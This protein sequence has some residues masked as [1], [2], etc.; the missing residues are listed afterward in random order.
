MYKTTFSLAV[1]QILYDHCQ[2][3]PSL[4]QLDAAEGMDVII[5]GNIMGNVN[6]YHTEG[7]G[8]GGCCCGCDCDDHEHDPTADN[9]D[10]EEPI[11][12]PDDDGDD[13]D[14]GD[15]M[16]DYCDYVEHAE[17]GPFKDFAST[18]DWDMHGFVTDWN[19]L[20]PQDVRIDSDFIVY[21]YQNI[22]CI[23]LNES[24]D[25]MLSRGGFYFRELFDY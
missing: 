4:D 11:T 8:E 7:N 20:E 21:V 13:G 19:W 12:V 6:I 3:G 18:L 17:A 1:F 5:K 15:D 22:C 25:M 10:P 14:D 2:A 24:I 23:H 16:I 9:G